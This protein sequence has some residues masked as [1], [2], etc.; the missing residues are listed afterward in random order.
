MLLVVLVVNN[1]G[2]DTQHYPQ[3][4]RERNVD[5]FYQN[6]LVNEHVLIPRYETESLVR[7][8]ISLCKKQGISHIVDI[9]TGS[10]VIPLS[11]ANNLEYDFLGASDISTSALQVAK[12][13]ADRL[14]FGVQFFE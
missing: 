9:G 14:G 1:M 7:H 11:L 2:I 12:K 10:V 3:E 5:F 4:Y 8:C 13:N 6:F